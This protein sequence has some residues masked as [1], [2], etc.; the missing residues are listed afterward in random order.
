MIVTKTAPMMTSWSVFP[1]LTKEKKR[2]IKELKSTI[3]DLE[4]VKN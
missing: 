1:V 2:K 3:N 4:K